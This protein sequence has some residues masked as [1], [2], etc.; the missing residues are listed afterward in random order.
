MLS[1]I[2][3]AFLFRSEDKRTN[4]KETY[5]EQSKDP[6]GTYIVLEL[7]K[8]YFPEKDL[9]LIKDSLSNILPL[10]FAEQINYVFIGEALHFDSLDIEHILQVVANGGNA[11][12]SSRTIPDDLMYYIYDG[13][14]DGSSWYDYE[15]VNDSSAQLSVLHPNLNKDSSNFTYRFYR[16]DL[17][18]NYRW[19]YIYKS[20]FCEDEFGLTAIGFMKDSLSNFA[21]IAYGNGVIY[22]HTTPLAFTNIQLLEEAHLQYAN[23]VFSHLTPGIIYWDRYNRAS[24][25]V[26]KRRNAQPPDS[27]PRRITSKGPLQYIL[28][29]PPLAW[30]WYLL[31]FSALLYL[32]FR[33][34]RRQRV[35]PVLEK[36]RNTSLEFLATIGQ[37]YFLQNN[38][39]KLALQKMKYFG[40]FIRDR[41]MMNFNEDSLERIAT[42]SEI[43]EEWIQKILL[44][45]KNIEN[46]AF[47]SENTLKEFHQ[48][49]D[50]FYKNC[51]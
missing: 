30:A 16:R 33:A 32:I 22:L 5:D 9:I 43:D 21:K 10:T 19:Q 34:K 18:P 37:L 39:R 35:I 15:E 44:V 20:Y 28:E 6:Y 2:V 25:F 23:K 14:C 29:Q 12:I 40:N 47:V 41:Y 46:S 27:S 24:E 38:H 13:Y 45:Y 17:R 3:L 51:K 11:F 31:L 26:G 42:K 7:L 50:Y 49:I 4:W 36:N 48:L 1:L 8:S